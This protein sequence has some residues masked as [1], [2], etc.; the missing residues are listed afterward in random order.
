MSWDDKGCNRNYFYLSVRVGERTK[1][2]YFGR[3]VAAKMAAD[4]IALQKAERKLRAATWQEAVAHWDAATAITGQLLDGVELVA[5][6]TLLAAGFHRPS[7]HTWR[8]RHV[9]KGR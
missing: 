9:E 2:K 7:R 6:A 5:S 3:G 1:K 4:W 8:R